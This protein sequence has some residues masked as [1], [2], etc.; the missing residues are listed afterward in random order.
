ML[1]QVRVLGELHQVDCPQTGEYCKTAWGKAC[2]ET[3]MP[4]AK[5]KKSSLHTTGASLGV[6]LR[7]GLA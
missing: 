5:P 3:I 1:L 2:P 6:A 7:T 4:N